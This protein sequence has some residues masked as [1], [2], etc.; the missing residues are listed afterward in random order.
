MRI[1]TRILIAAIAL[2]LIQATAA[3]APL[4]IGAVGTDAAGNLT[5]GGTTNIAPGNTLLVDIVSSGFAPTSKE[6]ASEFYGASGTVTVEAGDP[7][8]TWT[9]TTDMLPPETYTVTVDWVEGE[10]T[11]SGTFTITNETVSGVT[12][13]A[14][15]APPSATTPIP[16]TTP[17]PTQAPLGAGGI[18]LGLVAVLWM[19]RP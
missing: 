7:Y 15:T 1:I 5:V 16:P 4:E 19:R 3:A 14:T 10:A 2:G 6:E 18:L 17:T 11:A 8:N 9:F 12:T 13:T